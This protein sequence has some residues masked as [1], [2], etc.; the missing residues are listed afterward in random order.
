MD[1]KKL[2]QQ[3]EEQVRAMGERELEDMK[4]PESLS[5]DKMKE[6]ILAFE[7]EKNAG[8]LLENKEQNEKNVRKFHGGKWVRRAGLTLASVA[9]A[10]ALI[11]GV[12]NSDDWKITSKDVITQDQTTEGSAVK[13]NM[14]VNHDHEAE[15]DCD[16]AQ[17]ETLT[18]EEYREQLRENR[19]VLDGVVK[20]ESYEEL[21]AFYEEHQLIERREEKKTTFWDAVGQIINGGSK[22]VAV[23]DSIEMEAMPESSMD[24]SSTVTTK[25]ELMDNGVMEDAMPEESG[26]DLDYSDTNVQ[27][28]GVD[29]SDI[30][31][32]DGKYI[33]RLSNRNDE[34]VIY[35]ADGPAVTMV[36][37][38]PLNQHN[39]DSYRYYSDML[40]MDG[41]LAVLGTVT[42]YEEPAEDTVWK[43]EPVYNDD[44]VKNEVMVDVAYADCIVYRNSATF[45]EL[46]VYDVTEP[47]APQK[48]T[49]RTQEGSYQG[50]RMVDGIIYLMS[51][52]GA[53]HYYTCKEG[54]EDAYFEECYIPMVDGEKM[55]ASRIY[56]PEEPDTPSCVVIT[57]TDIKDPYQYLDS[58][59]MLGD[60]S[61]MYMSNQSI[62]LWQTKWSWWS[63]TESNPETI[64]TILKY[65]YEDGILTAGGSAQIQGYLNN[66]FSM[67][68]YQGYLRVVATREYDKIIDEDGDYDVVEW[69]TENQLFVFNDKMQMVGRIQGL[70]P[71]E[72]VKSARFFGDIGYFVTFRQTDPLFSVDLSDP[73]NPRIIGALKI[74]GFSEYLHPYGEGLLLGLGQEADE[75]T[76]GT[77]GVKLSMFDVSDPTNVKEIAKLVV[78]EN[79]EWPY[80]SAEYNHRAILASAARNVIG[81]S[82]E[83]GGY[84]NTEQG[85]EWYS[86]MAYCLY[87]YVEGQGFVELLAHGYE[88]WESYENVRGIYIG[89]YL[90]LVGGNRQ[91]AVYDMNDWSLQGHYTFYGIEAH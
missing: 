32:T 87:S 28:E 30:I 25:G 1:K 4:L 82:L 51:Y 9:A 77:Q 20:R 8:E 2:E 42:V 79:A 24:T 15:E 19:E 83:W 52:K 34:I 26:S 86:D 46:T 59:A 88:D 53:S 47:A 80:S 12:G 67:D 64:T 72:Y 62:Y 22:E 27:V 5:P 21:K 13:G 69:T 3:W 35:Q 66:S 78:R 38:I 85:T 55:A 75:T 73:T 74:P 7:Q 33:Y 48:L 37:K 65:S 84:R 71:G 58:M 89:Q 70:A 56:L 45:T 41:R 31:K 68:E 14:E 43:E 81:F 6:K 23:E 63:P 57:S 44:M 40:L 76:G 16:C 54:E 39:K 11:V 29:E 90:Y 60:A 36:G 50:V 49:T 61:Q 18:E 17:V 10:L 91:V